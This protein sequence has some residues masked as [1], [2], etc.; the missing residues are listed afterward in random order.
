M[1]T[2]TPFPL[3]VAIVA[4]PLLN[5]PPISLGNIVYVHLDKNNRLMR[6]FIQAPDK[7]DQ[8]HWIIRALEQKFG[9]AQVNTTRRETSIFGDL[10]GS[11]LM[12]WTFPNR[13]AIEVS[14][15]TGYFPSG[16]KIVFNAWP[17]AQY[18]TAVDAPRSN[19]T[20]L[21]GLTIDQ[22]LRLPECSPMARMEDIQKTCILN[23]TLRQTF[24]TVNARGG[25]V[26]YPWKSPPS[27]ATHDPVDV[28]VDEQGRLLWLRFRTN[29]VATQEKVLSELI[30]QFGEPTERFH[31]RDI[32]YALPIGPESLF[33]IWER[34][35]ARITFIGQSQSGRLGSV[36]LTAR[37]VI[38]DE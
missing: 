29:G 32:Q 33:A 18:I 36:M 12:Q 22:P 30:A 6:F 35:D 28:F 14:G 25:S 2:Q 37:R 3:E 31:A 13:G 15:A 5:Q 20:T 34:D 23:S 21:Y 16:G 26:F 7:L 17:M 4:F 8:S 1:T 19:T 9:P 11:L 10:E 38:P 24:G 27:I